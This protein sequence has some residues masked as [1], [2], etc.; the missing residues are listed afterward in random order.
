MVVLFP[1][2]QDEADSKMASP[3]KVIIFFLFFSFFFVGINFDK[4]LVS[5]GAVRG[6]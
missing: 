3:W 6:L 4:K 5:G 2:E 1:C